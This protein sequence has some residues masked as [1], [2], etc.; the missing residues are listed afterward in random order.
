M[1]EAL[2]SIIECGN[3]EGG[4]ISSK[5]CIVQSREEEMDP[6][7]VGHPLQRCLN[8]VEDLLSMQE[9]K[10]FATPVRTHLAAALLKSL[11]HVTIP[12]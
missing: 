7:R 1:S 11:W 3:G 10:P 6:A 8:V 12:A 2:Q 9:A 4:S 5:L